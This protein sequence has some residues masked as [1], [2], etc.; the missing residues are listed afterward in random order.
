MIKDITLGQFFP[1]NS[2]IHR[3]DPGMKLIMTVVWL[4]A[5][6]FANSAVSYALVIASVFTVMALSRVPLKM[7]FKSIKPLLFIIIFTALINLMYS[8]EGDTVLFRFWIV[9]VS[10]EGII[11]AVKIAIRI[12]LIVFVTSVLTYTTSPVSLAGGLEKLLSPLTNIKIP[13]HEFSMMMTIALRFIPTLLDETDK[14]MSAQK[15]RGTDFESG[16]LIKRARA[17]IPIIIP[18]FVSAFRRAEELATAMESRCYSA[19][20]TN[21]T[22]LIRYKAGVKDFVSLGISAVLLAA[23]ILLNHILIFGF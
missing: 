23:T 5:L 12:V 11:H 8:S 21:R 18:L 20:S 10:A 14:I 9:S 16:G 3:F 13:V 4:V 1:G 15:A 2:L 17:V 22:H 19:D 7:Y 6:F